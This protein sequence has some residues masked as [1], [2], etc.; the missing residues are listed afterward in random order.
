VAETAASVGLDR[1]L[2]DLLAKRYAALQPWPGGAA[3]LTALAA[4]GIKL[5]VATNCSESLGRIAARRIG[6]PFA[7]VVTAERAGFYKPD[8]HPYRLALE[9]L[10]IAPE[11]CLFVA[12]SAY[13]LAR[14]AQ[15]GLA[16]WWHDRVGME[17][18]LDAPEPLRHSRSLEGLEDF[19]LGG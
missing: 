16:T 4:A 5:G 14:A 19:V 18:P 8:P 17:K 3:A 9:E 13:D 15:V 2:A 12:G 10:R 1:R 6:V 7:A 11:H